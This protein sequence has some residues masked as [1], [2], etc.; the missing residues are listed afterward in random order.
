M[1]ISLKQR[2]FIV[3]IVLLICITASCNPD[4]LKKKNP[5]IGVWKVI[6]TSVIDSEGESKNLYEHPSLYVFYE[7]Y[8]CMVMVLGDDARTEF[9]DPWN[10][11]D[12][13]KRAAYDSILVNAGTYELRDSVIITRPIIARV[14]NFVGGEAYYEYKLQN[15][16]LTLIMFNEVSS[17]GIP[18]PW[19]GR[20]KYRRVLNRINK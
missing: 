6:E 20:Q 1:G 12:D 19:V 2:L 17:E 10:P 5:L 7:E 8:Y 9:K 11:T 16:A 3:Q 18:Q 14:P 4:Y 15:H 13:E